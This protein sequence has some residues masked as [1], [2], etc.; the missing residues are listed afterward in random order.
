MKRLNDPVELYTKE[1][2][3]KFIFYLQKMRLSTFSPLNHF[4]EKVSINK[5]Y[6]L[7][8][9]LIFLLCFQAAGKMGEDI[10]LVCKYGVIT[11]QDVIIMRV[12]AMSSVLKLT[13]DDCNR[14]TTTHKMSS[15]GTHNS[16]C[17]VNF[18]RFL[19]IPNPEE[20][21]GVIYTCAINFA[22]N[23]SVTEVPLAGNEVGSESSKTFKGKY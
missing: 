9:Q 13:Q 18:D 5:E 1:E 15:S 14:H 8:Y 16:T 22:V 4:N 19:E 11:I 6:K 3:F 12:R 23:E 20:A 10:S 7:I 2:V 21:A 17:S